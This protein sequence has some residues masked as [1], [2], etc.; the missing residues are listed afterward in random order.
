MQLAGEGGRTV[1]RYI[2]KPKE[3]VKDDK[4]ALVILYDLM[5]FKT[6]S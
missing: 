1:T 5:G 4:A 6:V 3:G 2:V